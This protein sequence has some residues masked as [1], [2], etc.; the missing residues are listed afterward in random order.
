MLGIFGSS[1]TACLGAEDVAAS[2]SAGSALSDLPSD[3]DAS[4]PPAESCPDDQDFEHLNFCEDGLRDLSADSNN[5]GACGHPCAG[6]QRCVAG[7][8]T[9]TCQAGYSQCSGACRDTVTDRLN[10]GECGN[11]CDSG[12]VC[13][14]G[15]CVLNERT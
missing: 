13:S 7:E 14:S 9:L 10:C 5:C 3:V 12:F 1:F 4:S 8:C 2:S 6:G 15:S 11:R